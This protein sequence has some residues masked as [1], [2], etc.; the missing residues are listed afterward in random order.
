MVDEAIDEGDNTGGVGEHLVPF[1]KGTVGGDEGARL[2]IAARDELEEEV[3]MAVGIGE[4]ADLIDDEEEGTC[5]MAQPP[6]QCGV[7]V[8]RS[9]FAYDV[10]GRCKQQGMAVANGWLVNIL[11]DHRFA[12]AVGRDKDHVASV[13]EELE[14]HQPLD[15]TSVTLL[16]PGPIE[17]AQRFEAPD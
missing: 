5:V 2:L 9:E 13:L 12:E 3:G 4:V 10:A 15:S 7:A 17:V 11:G 8:T 16:G 6:A 1:G 14:R